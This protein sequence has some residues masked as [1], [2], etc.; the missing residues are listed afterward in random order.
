MRYRVTYEG[1][2]RIRCELWPGYTR[3]DSLSDAFGFIER[4]AAL[5]AKDAE[6]ETH[7]GT[8]DAAVTA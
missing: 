4:H 6:R 2:W 3:A 8:N 5:V 1:E 7:A